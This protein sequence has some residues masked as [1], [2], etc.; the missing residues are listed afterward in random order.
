[1]GLK[2]AKHLLDQ[3]NVQ[4]NVTCSHLQAFCCVPAGVTELNDVETVS[5][6][7]ALLKWNVL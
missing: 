4:H 6:S 3:Q 7:M 1:M 2:V 5:E